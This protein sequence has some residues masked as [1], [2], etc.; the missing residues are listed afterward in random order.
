[1][2]TQGIQDQFFDLILARFPR[3][4]DAVEALCGILNLAKDP[5]YRRLRG[6]TFLSPQEMKTLAQ[7]F[8]I[9]L[10]SLIYEGNNDVLCTFSDFTR[11]VKTFTD[12]LEFF[13]GDFELIN[14]FPSPHLWYASAELP[15]FSYNLFPELMSFKLYVWG[16]TTWNFD[17][18]RERPFSFDLI[19]DPMLQLV[20]LLFLEV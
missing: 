17:W 8:R 13:E 20:V 16:R 7:H 11:K 19:T 6:D 3:R 18:L 5:V 4:A 14:K 10:D 1:M 2:P 12:Y 9:S 15:V